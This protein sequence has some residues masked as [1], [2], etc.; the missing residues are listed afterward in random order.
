MVGLGGVFFRSQDPDSLAAW[1]KEHFGIPY[2]QK[3][4][5]WFPQSGPVVMSPFPKDTDYFGGPQEVMVNF[6]VA[7]LDAFLA[8]LAGSGIHEVKE[9]ETM[10]D[11]GRFAWVCDPEGRRIEL[12][13]PAKP[14]A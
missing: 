5:P 1:Y 6:R 11:V 14:E 8:D 12:W 3:E 10:E 2:G 7:D 4:G 13:E 9:Q